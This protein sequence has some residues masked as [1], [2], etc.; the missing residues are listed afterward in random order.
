MGCVKNRGVTVDNSDFEGEKL[1][2]RR[3]V[4]N[5]SPLDPGNGAGGTPSPH[6]SWCGQRF[7]SQS[8]HLDRRTNGLP[9][10]SQEKGP[11]QMS[12]P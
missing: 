4:F 12:R 5:R 11:T 6:E 9:G 7:I 10:K 2:I 3:Q 8:Q 1:W